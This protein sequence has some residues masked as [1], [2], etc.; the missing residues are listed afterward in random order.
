[1]L[2]PVKVLFLAQPFAQCAARDETRGVCDDKVT[3]QMTRECFIRTSKTK[4]LFQEDVDCLKKSSWLWVW[5]RK[6]SWFFYVTK[7]IAA[8]TQQAFVEFCLAVVGLKNI[9]TSKHF[10]NKCSGS[11]TKMF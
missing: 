5:S 1:M 9:S 3:D 8:K 7:N 10:T 6:K 2:H 11:D 4:Q